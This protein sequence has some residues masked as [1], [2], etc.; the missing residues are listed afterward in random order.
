MP[1]PDDWILPPEVRQFAIEAGYDPDEIAEELAE[2][3]SRS[4]TAVSNQERVG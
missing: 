2:W 4:C 1:L 3:A